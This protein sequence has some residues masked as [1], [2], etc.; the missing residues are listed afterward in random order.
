MKKYIACCV[1]LL[2]PFIMPTGAQ[3]LVDVGVLGGYT[4]MGDIEIS[5]DEYDGIRGYQ[6]GV[7]AHLNLNSDLF[8]LGFGFYAQKG[9]WTYDANGTNADFRLKSSWGPD[10]IFMLNVSSTS[11]PYARI[12]FSFVDSLEYDYGPEY[13]NKTRFLNSGW[14]ALGLGLKISPLIVLFA[15]F[16]RCSTGL[17]TIDSHTNDMTRNMVNAGIMMV[18]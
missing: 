10:I 14:W 7:F 5:D 8:M 13:K 4:F 6:F 1:L 3:A 16:Q 11:R 15:E 2:L 12:G 17:N 18:Y 9:A